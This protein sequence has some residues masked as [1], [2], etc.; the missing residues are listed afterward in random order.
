MVGKWK[1]RAARVSIWHGKPVKALLTEKRCPSTFQGQ[2]LAGHSPLNIE[3]I[4]RRKL[5]SL[6]VLEFFLRGLQRFDLIIA[7]LRGLRI[8]C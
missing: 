4:V 5:H 3:N 8:E 7:H 2:C 6:F 1:N